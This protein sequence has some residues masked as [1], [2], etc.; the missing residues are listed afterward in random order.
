VTGASFGVSHLVL[1]ALGRGEIRPE[2]SCDL[3]GFHAEAARRR[4]QQFVEESVAASR[5]AVLVICG[6]G[7]HSGSEGPVLREVAIELLCRPPLLAS[8]LA[9]STAAE[10]LGG[11]GAIVILLRRRAETR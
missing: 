5:R 4:V 6:R 10:A 1:R 2:A 9:F 8:V 7:R 11:N 3:H